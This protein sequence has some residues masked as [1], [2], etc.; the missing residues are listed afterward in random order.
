MKKYNKL[1][2]QNHIKTLSQKIL[3]RKIG[4]VVGTRPGIVMFSPII[5]ECKKRRINHF[6]IHAGQHYSANMDEDFF[7]DLKLDKPRY[8]LTNVRRY[9]LHGS[10][11]A[12]MIEGIEKILLKERPKILLV[13]GDANCNLAG[14]LAAR[15][16]Q[17]KVGHIEAGERSYDWRMPEEHNRVIIDHISDLLFTTNKKGKSNLRK[18]GAR[19]KICITGNPI[20]DAAYQNKDI[21][22][23]RSRVLEKFGLQPEEYFVMTTHREENV[24]NRAN[25]LGILNGIRKVACDLNKT[26]I[27]TIH[28]RTRTRLKKFRLYDFVKKIPNV[29][30][31]Q[32][33]GYLDFIRLITYAKLIMTDSGGVQQ[34]SC[35]LGVPCITFRDNTEWTETLDIGANRLCGTNSEAIFKNAKDMLRKKN[36]W[37][38]PFGSGDAAKKII[39]LTSKYAFEEV[40]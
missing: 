36:D 35:I 28:P 22:Y 27:F 7:K 16:L 20:V 30:I 13:G 38:N 29:K 6:V 21:A 5:R 17:I 4:L 3:K 24:D 10:Q 25:L 9:K 37:K 11:T 23:L 19:G 40:I 39:S 14:A 26:I 34:E 33:V 18:D 31:I 8:R 32:P 2:S 12:R 1:E 15:K